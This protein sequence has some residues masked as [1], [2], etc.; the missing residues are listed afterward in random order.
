MWFGPA[1]GAG[2]TDSRGP[3]RRPGVDAAR[4]G[5]A[6]DTGADA[7]ARTVRTCGDDGCARGLLRCAGSFGQA[8]CLGE[9][10]RFRKAGRIGCCT[11]AVG[12]GAEACCIRSG[13]C[14]ICQEVMRALLL[15]SLLSLFVV[16]TGCRESKPAEPS[17]AAPSVASSPTTAAAP[18]APAATGE[19]LKVGDP[20]PSVP[21]QLDL[22]AYKGKHVVVYFY[23]KDDTPGCTKEACAFRDAWSKLEKANV[24]VLGVSIDDDASHKKFVEKYKLPFPLIADTDQKI[25]KAYGVSVTA[26][27]ASRVSYLIGPDG[28]IKKVYPKVDPSVHADEILADA[29]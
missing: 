12:V 21:P 25:C 26:G 5:R 6:R 4:E 17:N 28:K 13:T 7:V 3:E 18:S 9:A 29:A 16:A 15:S 14:G 10:R 11:E 8:R 27:Y 19:L 24:Q 20:A 2:H 1:A 23:P 22:A